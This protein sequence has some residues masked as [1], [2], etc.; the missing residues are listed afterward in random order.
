MEIKFSDGSLELPENPAQAGDFLADMVR[1][2]GRNTSGG[3]DL[4]WD[5]FVDL[6]QSPDVR[7]LLARTVQQLIR[8]PLDPIMVITSL[9]E[10]VQ[11]PMMGHQILT[12]A[13]GAFYA[14]DVGEHTAYPEVQFQIGGGTQVAYVGKSG[15]QA[16]FTDEALRASTWDLMALHLREMNRALK[17]H[18][19]QK[20]VSFLKELGT[21]LFNNLTPETSLFGVTTGRGISMAAN[22]TLIMDDLFQGM[23]HMSEEGFAPDVLLI[24]PLFFYMFIQDPVMRN[25]M[26]AHGG[27]DYFNQWTGNPGPQDPWSNGSMGKLGPSRGNRITPG[28][29]LR[30]Q[31]EAGRVATGVAGR[32]HGMTAAPPLPTSYFPWNFRVVVSPLVPFDKDTGSGDLLLLSSNDIGY[33]LV[34]E[35]PVQVEWRD[36]AVDKTMIKLRERYGFGLANE[37]QAVGVFK[38]VRLDRQYWDGTVQAT[39]TISA[40]IAADADLTSLF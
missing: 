9:F 39:G 33:L 3:R 15:I 17:R 28:P 16:S 21:E 34:D 38:N 14:G 13:M 18:K 31:P 2:H 8:E 19:E 25:M 35:E 5:E 7:P 6:T 37:G 1:N 30:G 22:G 32:E 27:G 26:L 24:N 36:E 29:G 12:G 11:A 40:D 10:K 4:K 23:A 20:A